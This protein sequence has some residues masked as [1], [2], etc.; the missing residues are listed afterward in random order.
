M[1]DGKCVTER[2]VEYDMLTVFFACLWSGVC[3]V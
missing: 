1:C 3:D 2:D